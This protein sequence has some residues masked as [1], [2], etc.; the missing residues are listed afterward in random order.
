[1]YPKCNLSLSPCNNPNKTYLEFREALANALIRNYNSR[2][3]HY[4]THAHVH[5]SLVRNTQHY[6]TKIT[7]SYCKHPNC[8]HQTVWYCSSC[9]KR[10]W[11][12]GNV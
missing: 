5:T 6:P 9:D 1:M 2:K 4:I 8:K 11:H 10:F 7:M 3:R 12:T